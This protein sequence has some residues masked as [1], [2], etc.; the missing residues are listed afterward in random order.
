MKPRLRARGEGVMVALSMV[1]EMGPDVRRVD[2]VPM[3]RSSVLSALSL[4]KLWVN[5]DF[6]AEMQVSMWARGGFWVGF[7]VL[8]QR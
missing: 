4:R 7:V 6:I 2:L 5:H 8:V 3:R 1:S